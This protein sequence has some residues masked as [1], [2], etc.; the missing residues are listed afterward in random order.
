MKKTTIFLLTLILCVGLAACG[1]NNNDMDNAG[2]GTGPGNATENGI[3]GGNGGDGNPN[4]A[5]NNADTPVKIER[6]IDAVADYL[7]L[8][9]G[10]ETLYEVIGAKEGKEY[11]GG[12]VELYRFDRDSAEYKA[13]KK[14]EGSVKA[15]STKDGFVLLFTGAEDREMVKKFKEMRLK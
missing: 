12:K 13:I 7:N 10:E 1:N 9:N 2:A 6:N 3:A 11:N 4:P 14:G 8:K 5:Q 15:A